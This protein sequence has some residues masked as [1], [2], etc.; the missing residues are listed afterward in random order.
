MLEA[1]GFDLSTDEIDPADPRSST[2]R[3]AARPR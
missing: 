2:G 1:L 3:A